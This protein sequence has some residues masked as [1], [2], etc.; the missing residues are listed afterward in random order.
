MNEED[1]SRANGF[2]N[3]LLMVGLV[4]LAA[5]AICFFG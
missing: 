3:K 4:L 5:A 1:F 2:A